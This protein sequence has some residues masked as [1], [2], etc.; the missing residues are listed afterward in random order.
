ML[1]AG[2][3][4]PTSATTSRAIRSSRTAENAGW[5][6]WS[7][8][9][10]F[11]K[12]LDQPRH[13]DRLC[14]GPADGGVQ[15]RRVAEPSQPVE[16]GVAANRGDRRPQLVR[17]VGE[18]ATEALLRRAT[19]AERLLDP[20]QHRVQR[21]AE[22]AGL[23][24][25]RRCRDP[26]REV[27]GGHLGRRARH[28]S[29]RSDAE[30]HHPPRDQPEQQQHQEARHRQHPHEPA[31]DVVHV[32]Q[33]HA[34]HDGTARAGGT[35]LDGHPILGPLHRGRH[36]DGA[37]GPGQASRLLD[38]QLGD[39]GLLRTQAG[40]QQGGQLVALERPDEQ[41]RRARILRCGLRRHHRR[42][43]SEVPSPRPGTLRESSELLVQLPDQMTGGDPRHRHRREHHDGRDQCHGEE[44]PAAQRH[45]DPPA[46]RSLSM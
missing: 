40:H 12:V 26:H 11:Q 44:E 19:L 1:R 7:R 46:S 24:A 20:L 27:A 5:S 34:D 23:G 30:S 33:L 36:G 9:A 39:S 31:D 35:V 13:A 41:A 2:C 29:Q 45:A 6:P 15:C 43:R 18:E 17:R 14:L 42:A 38:P 10:S 16:L 22:L 3:T 8:R 21:S 4:T 28:L 25:G 32:V 37:S